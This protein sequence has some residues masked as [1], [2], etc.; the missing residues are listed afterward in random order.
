VIIMRVCKHKASCL[1]MLLAAAIIPCLLACSPPPTL[2]LQSDTSYVFTNLKPGI[3]RS[4]GKSFTVANTGGQEL[5]G[6]VTTNR[7]WLHTDT[8]SISAKEKQ[9]ISFWVDTKNFSYDY[10][11]AGTILVDSNGGKGSIDVSLSTVSEPVPDRIDTIVVGK[12]PQYVWINTVTNR[13]YVYSDMG[14]THLAK[15]IMSS[16]TGDGTILPP[17]PSFTIID[18]SND[19]VVCIFDG[20]L[21]KFAIT[22]LDDLYR[23][24][25]EGDVFSTN[26]GKIFQPGLDRLYPCLSFQQTYFQYLLSASIFGSIGPVSRGFIVTPDMIGKIGGYLPDT[27]P[28][29]INPAT[30]RIYTVYSSSNSISV[31]D[32]V[33]N[34][35]ITTIQVGSNPVAIAVNPVNNRVYVANR[36]DNT[37]SVI[38]GDTNKLAC[39]ISVDR[40]PVD[41]AVN[42]NTNR[43]YVANWT[44]YTITV[45]E[46]QF[47]R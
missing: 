30:S 44:G 19:K 20:F 45:L 18:G 42:P 2:S 28:S 35:V 25:C 10:S 22:S 23:I 29:A 6:I 12:N 9:D 31:S 16:P 39:N 1:G 36:D 26:S 8:N 21:P 41:I 34:Q 13:V 11:D 4:E 17:A 33:S 38:N 5:R 7:A 46:D 15:L 3:D 40:E 27:K 14:F 24:S 37:V 43:I 47:G 32:A